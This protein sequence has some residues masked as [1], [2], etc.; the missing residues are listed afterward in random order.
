MSQN[1]ADYISFSIINDKT[2]GALTI[3]VTSVPDYKVFDTE[4]D[5]AAAGAIKQVFTAIIN[6][7]SHFASQ[8]SVSAELMLSCKSAEN[9]LFRSFVDIHVVLRA[10]DVDYA[11][12]L[13]NLIHC[14]TLFTETLGNSKIVCEYC[15]FKEYAEIVSDLNMD[16]VLTIR[17]PDEYIGFQNA[18]FPFCYNYDAVEPNDKDIDAIV[19]AMIA[20]KDCAV[21]LSI[22]PTTFTYAEQSFLSV[23]YNSLNRLCTGIMMPRMGMYKE[24][25]AEIP[26]RTYKKYS[27]FCA[28]PVCL[29][30][31]Q[32]C[33]DRLGARNIASKFLS[34]L[35]DEK[36]QF[37]T[38]FEICETNHFA[39][40][41]KS[42]YASPWAVSDAIMQYNRVASP[43]PQMQNA[44]W[45]LAYLYLPAEI[46]QVFRVPIGTKKI[47]DGIDI[48]YINKR[49]K[50][51]GQDVINSAAF[52]IGKLQNVIGD[53]SYIGVG[54]KDLTKHMLV[55]GTPGSGKS[56]FLVGLMDRLWKQGIPFLVIEPAKTEY[57]GLIDSIPDLQ[58]FSPGNNEVSPYVIN[59]F[60]PPKGVSVEKHKSIVKAAFSAAF[61]MW[62]PL[63][64]LFDETLNICYSE[65]GWL[66]SDVVEEGADC[67]SLIDFVKTYREVV[68]SKGYSGEY[69]KQIEAAGVLRLNGLLEQNINIFDTRYSVP[70]EDILKAPTV[71]ELSNVKDIKQKSFIIAYLLN[72]IYAYVEANNSN[73]GNLKNVI[74]LE[75]AHVLLDAGSVMGDEGPNANAA[76]VKLLTDMLA[77]I[78]SRGVGIVVADQSPKKVTSPVISNT[79]VKVMFRLVEKA[80]KEIVKNSTGMTDLQEERLSRLSTGEALLYFDKLDEVEEIRMDDYRLSAGIATDL[81]DA[82]VKARITYWQKHAYLLKPF[83]DCDCIGS[84]SGGCDALKRNRA[85]IIADRIF[86]KNYPK[87][88]H[89]F[90]TFKTFYRQMNV[91]VK[92]ETLAVFKGAVD[93]A[94]V[95]DCVKVHFLRKVNYFT[96]IE[97]N[98]T[99]R[100]N[101]YERAKKP[102]Q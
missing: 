12:C 86:R 23:N 54:K 11:A 72:N 44:C 29:F 40:L 52:T 45:R 76:A 31:M 59:P 73:D 53:Q 1:V 94:D 83:P 58:V 66:D 75:E 9:Q 89:D 20:E 82:D 99:L 84:C 87:N 8:S 88:F 25:R 93:P 64:Q 79:N 80:D 95:L 92:E 100:K 47:T 37:S 49:N 68:A 24:A 21:V 69:K 61:E 96:N 14:G 98:F 102:L 41:L 90:E 70:I 17:R 63:D 19:N 33:G 26:M 85:R 38:R 28:E 4:D 32:V 6:E 34:V 55:V 15:D 46:A 7:F 2:V 67:F 62:T 43:Y 51:F 27:A 35:T 97:V 65:Q 101:T 48:H 5:V 18:F 30:N 16:E 74:L 60:V 36:A 42:I 22:I 77:E 50:K 56:T 91:A 10:V 13:N 81:R 57:R 3:H 39:D 78:R 71:I